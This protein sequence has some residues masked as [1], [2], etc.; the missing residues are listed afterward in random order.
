MSSASEE[1]RRGLDQLQHLG[2][3]QVAIR[4]L[5]QMF[6]QRSSYL[7]RSCPPTS[8]F[9][10]CSRDY[11]SVMFETLLVDLLW[12]VCNSISLAC[13]VL[14]CESIQVNLKSLV[15]R[16]QPSTKF[17]ILSTSGLL[18][19]V[20]EGTFVTICACFGIVDSCQ[21]RLLLGSVRTTPYSH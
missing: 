20:Q 18:T 2:D 14:N 1:D 5:K 4:I 13:G 3:P 7:L 10:E 15:V 9:R 6:A 11:D 19:V 21:S 16:R 17:L 12:G 8:A